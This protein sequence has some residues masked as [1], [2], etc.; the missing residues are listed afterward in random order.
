[1]EKKK[2]TAISLDQPLDDTEDGCTL[3]VADETASIILEMERKELRLRLEK[4]MDRLP[5]HLKELFVWRHINGMSYEEMAEIKK[6]PVGTVKN[7]VFQAKE[8]MRGL[9]E[10]MP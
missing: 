10:E 3:Q 8:M 7:R 9:L 6:L 5:V 2:I 1:L 4:A